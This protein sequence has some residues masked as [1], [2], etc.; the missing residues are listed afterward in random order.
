[1]SRIDAG[2]VRVKRESV[3]TSD[4]VDHAVE[5]SRTALQH[6]RVSRDVSLALPRIAADAA[7]A[8]TA[9]VNVLENAGKYAP[10]GSTISIRAFRKDHTVVIE[11]LDEGEGFPTAALPHLFDKFARGVEGDGRPAGT[12]LGLAIARGFLNAQGATIEA[13]NRADRVGAVVSMT[14]PVE[15]ERR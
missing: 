6:K 2:V 11:V 1:M 8:E 14:F 3:E 12:G 10:D 13:A 5:R 4:L 7:L 9:L 15:E